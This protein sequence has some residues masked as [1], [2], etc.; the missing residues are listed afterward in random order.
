MESK[1]ATS[2]MAQNRNDMVLSSSPWP[3]RKA[4]VEPVEEE[5]KI[6]QN[7]SPTQNLPSLES[8]ELEKETEVEPVEEKT[9]VAQNPSRTE[10]EQSYLESHELEKETEVAQNPSPT[11]NP[12]LHQGLIESKHPSSNASQNRND[13]TRSPTQHRPFPGVPSP[14]QNH[15]TR[16]RNALR[17]HDLIVQGQTVAHPV[18]SPPLITR[19]MRAPPLQ[20]VQE[21]QYEQLLKENTALKKKIEVL[22][23]QQTSSYKIRI[24]HDDAFWRNIGQKLIE[25]TDY[26]KSLLRSGKMTVFDET[27]VSKKTLLIMAARYGNYE[28]AQLALN[29]GADIDHKDEDNR[30]ALDHANQQ[31]QH[32]TMQLLTLNKMEANI[33]KRVS[34][35]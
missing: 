2:E 8:H 27:Y 19:F 30:T 11:G 28:I 9:T 18:R 6:A 23:K 24:Q 12:P 21:P 16:Y 17:S 14:A 29:L 34:D 25:D 32:H 22:E 1:E 5:T 33:S 13:M 15:P 35:T 20:Q 31:S 7:P 26:V 4:E 10:S 3:A